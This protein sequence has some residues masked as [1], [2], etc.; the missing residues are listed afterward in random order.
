MLFLIKSASAVG[1]NNA[2]PI[3]K[4]EE[5]YLEKLAKINKG[6]AFT[7]TDTNKSEQ[8]ELRLYDHMQI[9]P[10]IIEEVAEN[11][12]NQ[13]DQF[14][15]ITYTLDE[16]K[17]ISDISLC[18]PHPDT[19]ELYQVD[20]WKRF[21]EVVEIDFNEE[22]FAGIRDDKEFETQVSIGDYGIVIDEEDKAS[23]TES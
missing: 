9:N 13:F 10:V 4:R 7:T 11:L 21:F 3:R 8:L 2:L 18:L 14:Y 1:N 6:V 19:Y 5:N 23:D 16:E 17:M 12:N 22:D 20:S 15:I